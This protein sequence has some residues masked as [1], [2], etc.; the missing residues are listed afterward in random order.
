MILISNKRNVFIFTPIFIYT[1]ASI[2]NSSC[3][4]FYLWLL[5]CKTCFL[6]YRVA[7]LGIEEREKKGS[8]SKDGLQGFLQ[9]KSI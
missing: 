5:L 4:P 6:F 7:L 9:K 1:K 3:K 2:G 8:R